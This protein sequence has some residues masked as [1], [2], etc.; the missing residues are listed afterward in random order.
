MVPFVC[1]ANHSRIY[2]CVIGMAG[3][4]YYSEFYRIVLIVFLVARLFL[5]DGFVPSG[6]LPLHQSGIRAS[7]MAGSSSLGARDAD[8]NTD[9]LLEVQARL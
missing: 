6:C 5:I 2:I 9:N 3:Q 1:Y 8:R 7:T 4:D